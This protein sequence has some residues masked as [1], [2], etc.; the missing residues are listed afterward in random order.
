MGVSPTFAEMVVGLNLK[1]K[2]Q[3]ALRLDGLEE[4]GHIRRLSSKPRA[5]EIIDCGTSPVGLP[6]NVDARLHSYCAKHGECR[7]DV[8]ADAVELHLDE[9]ERSAFDAAAVV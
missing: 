5:I 6:P 2:S 1:S 3:V 8:I 4:R 9:I 7:D